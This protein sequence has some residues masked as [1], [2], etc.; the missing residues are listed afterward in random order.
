MEVAAWLERQGLGQYAGAFS[1]HAIDLDVLADLDDDDLAKLGVAAIGHRK[2]LLKA[3]ADLRRS[4][5]DNFVISLDP[6]PPTPRR[7]PRAERRQVSVLFC[8][9]VG[10][11]ELAHRLDPEELAPITEQ[12]HKAASETVRQLGGHVARFVGDGVMAYFGWPTS[13]EDDAERAVEAGLELIDVVSRMP[14]VGGET[15]AVRVAVATGLVAIGY[16]NQLEDGGISGETPNVAARL[17]AEAE[18]N[19]LVVSP[20]TARLAG[21]SFPYRSLGLRPLRGLSEPM[22]IFVVD[23]ER[24]P[25]NRFRALRASTGP[26]V[27]R[28]EEVDLLLSRWRRAVDSEGHVVLLSGDAGIGKSRLVQSTR[29][30][31]GEPPLLLNYQ[32]SPLHQDT[33]LFP[34]AQHLARSIG[35]AADQS[36]ETRLAR[37]QA[38][39]EEMQLEGG[40]DLPLLCHLLQIRSPAHRL[41]EASPQQ[42]R[43]RLVAMLL[44]QFLRLAA[45]TPVLAI[46]ED[47]QWIDPTTEDLLIEAVRS[48]GQSQAMVLATSRDAFAQRWRA[49]GHTT[50][51][52]L[53]RLSNADSRRLIQAI[54]GERL[55]PEVQADIAG[56]AEGVP[57]YLEELTLAVI[58]VGSGEL[59]EVPTTL[60]GLL[61][62]RLDK[63]EDA[64]PLLQ[65]G[66]VLGRQFALADLQAVAGC[67]EADLR[68]MVGQSLA[69]GLLLAAEPGNESILMFKHALVQ[70]A[71]YAS[72]LNSEKRRLHGAALDHLE[73]KDWSATSGG[74]AVLAAH[75]ERGRLWD[76]A[77]VH[78]GASLAQAI[79]SSANREAIGLH[80]RLLKVIGRLPEGSATAAAV[81]ARL[82]AFSP[83]LALGELDRLVGVMREADALARQLGDKRRLA[84]TNSQLAT[85]LWLAGSHEAGLAA[86]EETV[87]L[88]GELDDFGLRLS[89]R[90]GR[91]NMLHAMGRLEP[92]AE[93][94]EG[95]LASLT[96]E[97]E[98]K[99]F[100]WPGV[101]SILARGLL[102]W[103]LV[104]LGA[105][106]RARAVKD[107]ALE[108]AARA[109]EPYSTVYAHMAE[110]LYCSAI[111]EP[112]AAI[113]AFEAAWRITQQGDIVLPISTAWLGAALTRGGRPRDA[114]ALLL[115]AE[116]RAAHRSGGLY[117]AIHHY[118]ALAQAH[119]AAGALPPAREAIER[120]RAI[121]EEAGELAH[122]AEVLRVRGAIEAADPASGVED[123]AAHYRRA[124]ELAEQCA[125][126]PLIAQCLADLATQCE[127]VGDEAA[128]RRHREAAMLASRALGL[129][130]A[131]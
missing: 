33:A 78:L 113:R 97:L 115:D 6:R 39:L 46:I 95:L 107:R 111:G 59:N 75:A 94:Y 64:K 82:H 129:T 10:S 29:E 36:V 101:P 130:S 13:R 49:P 116:R 106:E 4:R 8:D 76:R 71:A 41:P 128:A 88:A 124:L 52:R 20:L 92:A 127:R 110:G 3:I 48:I 72:L 43:E 51:L 1:D 120:A 2:R 23:G 104:T 65:I 105:F 35:L 80:D 25:I 100:G 58:E 77:A 21:R 63:L 73:R 57:L 62:A 108:L 69:S 103:T 45:R 67:S 89:G 87:R 18:P 54:A 37:L 85:A 38:W 70:D 26:L 91:A 66:A 9:L 14:S 86:A 117:N 81:D 11:T 109:R 28:S 83:L 74:T 68:A 93:E 56:R 30:R 79:R 118:M 31:I 50:E 42:L 5:A 121:A 27:G 7:R 99:R 40:P 96:G 24:S 102:T 114:L 19:M 34:I 15:L 16:G 61:A 125:M 90:F 32:C 126:R 22:E 47:V 131:A 98:L 119:L 122:L 84:V 55:S 53:D 123:A 17:Q 12:Y 60:Q 112:A 44:R